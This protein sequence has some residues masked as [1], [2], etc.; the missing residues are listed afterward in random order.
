QAEDGIRDFPVT[1][2]QTCALPIY[3][4]ESADGVG[5]LQH[6]GATVPQVGRGEDLLEVRAEVRRRHAPVDVELDGA[7]KLAALAGPVLE[8]RSEERRVG[9]GWA[10]RGGR[11]AVGV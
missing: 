10:S 3:A 8:G 1:G 4:H 9:K 5:H 7:E 2:V 11:G 6:R